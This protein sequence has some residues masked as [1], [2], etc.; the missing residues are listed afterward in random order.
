MPPKGYLKGGLENAVPRQIDHCGEESED[1]ES[2]N[3]D[4]EVVLHLGTEYSSDPS[5]Y[6][7]WARAVGIVASVA[8]F[9]GVSYEGI[10]R[11]AVVVEEVQEAVQAELNRLV[12]TIGFACRITFIV[13]WIGGM[14]YLVV[15]YKVRK[16]GDLFVLFLK[17][18]RNL[19]KPTLTD[20]W[21]P[22]TSEGTNDPS[23][24]E[25]GR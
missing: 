1:S 11:T 22:R 10:R 12:E 15:F 17:S 25:L 3:S 8:G 20:S 19:E 4:P 9:G 14:I 21:F 18:G 6:A 23:W 5:P 7:H 24:I 13:A 2:E 16:P